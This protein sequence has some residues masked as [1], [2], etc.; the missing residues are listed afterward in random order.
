MKQLDE[1]LIDDSL[2]VRQRG[3]MIASHVQNLNWYLDTR[4]ESER[5]RRLKFLDFSMQ[6]RS[7]LFPFRAM[8]FDKNMGLKGNVENYLAIHDLSTAQR[9]DYSNEAL[10]LKLKNGDN[11]S[12]RMLKNITEVH[13]GYVQ[14]SEN[15]IF[16]NNLPKLTIDEFIAG[17]VKYFASL[18]L[19]NSEVLEVFSN[20]SIDQFVKTVDQGIKDFSFSV[21]ERPHINP[22]IVYV[23]FIVISFLLLL[24][25]Y[26][27]FYKS[28]YM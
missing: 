20:L 27:I 13:N 16:A 7:L 18:D 15:S 19:P 8:M 6:A 22:I 2:S 11:L 10:V 12:Q 3:N 23:V 1:N 26:L 5:Y 9:V 4:K 14:V 24:A 28:N 21:T 25:S 17:L